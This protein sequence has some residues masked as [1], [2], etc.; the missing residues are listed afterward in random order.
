MRLLLIPLTVRGSTT[1]LHA[2][3]VFAFATYR[4]LAVT[5]RVDRF[6]SLGY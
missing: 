3:P 1:V 4:F 6:G 5:A 2:G